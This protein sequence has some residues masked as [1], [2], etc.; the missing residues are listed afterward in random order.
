MRSRRLPKG[1][2]WVS[3][4]PVVSPSLL[5]NTEVRFPELQ[6]PSYSQRPQVCSRVPV[7]FKM[8]PG[9]W[10]SIFAASLVCT[11]WASRRAGPCKATGNKI[12][13]DD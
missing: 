10:L 8:G 1:V 3:L 13:R 2:L 9:H 12:D 7:F 11:L 4:I 6:R 5:L